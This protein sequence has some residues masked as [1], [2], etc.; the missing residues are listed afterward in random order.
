[1]A[2]GS[3]L[4]SRQA[5][6]AEETSTP[7]EDVDALR[8]PERRRLQKRTDLAIPHSPCDMPDDEAETCDGV[9]VWELPCGR[10]RHSGSQQGTQGTSRCTSTLSAPWG[11]A[12]STRCGSRERP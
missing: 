2:R 5:R 1:M 8:G 12:Y 7:Q 6:R 11:D 3:I 4:R 10:T 9:R